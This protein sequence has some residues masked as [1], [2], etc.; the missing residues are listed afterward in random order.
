MSTAYR[1]RQ[2]T[3]DLAME[4][5]Y[6]RDDFLVGPSN[7]AAFEMVERWPDWPVPIMLITGPEGSGKSHLAAIWAGDAGAP[8]RLA[9]TLPGANLVALCQ[10][11]ALVIEDAD[12][13][14]TGENVLFH[15]LNLVRDHRVSLLMTA[16]SHPD[17]WG[18]ATPDLISRLRLAPVVE[19]APPDDEMLRA[20]IVKQ[21]LDRQIMI[22]ADVLEYLLPRM[23]RSFAGA[24]RLVA[25]LDQESLALGRRVSRALAASVF[26]A[27]P[28]ER[29]PD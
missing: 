2:L 24:A 17:T 22:D 19:I 21:F 20:L 15:L 16:R 8:V 25:A 10:E 4:P 12:R 27:I 3:L 11:R 13:I 18:I 9:S 6:S 29:H 26:G 28:E 7:A 14:G 23:E 5:R 1:P